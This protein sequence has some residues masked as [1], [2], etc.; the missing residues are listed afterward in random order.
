[1]E[2]NE[3]AHDFKSELRNWALV[4]IFWEVLNKNRYFEDASSFLWDFSL[5]YF[6]ISADCN[7]KSDDFKSKLQKL[8]SRGNF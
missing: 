7:E 1:M 5:K 8:S 2:C 6:L 3:K 4:G